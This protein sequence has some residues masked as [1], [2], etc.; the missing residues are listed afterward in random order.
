MIIIIIVIIWCTLIRDVRNGFLNFGLVSVFKKPRVRF[1]F[2]FVKIRGF[3]RFYFA[4]S[5]KSNFLSNIIFYLEGRLWA[6][7]WFEALV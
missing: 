3:V 5:T 2:G 7:Y 1:W 6:F 4:D